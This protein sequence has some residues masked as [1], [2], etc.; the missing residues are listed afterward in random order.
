MTKT[1]LEN[2]LRLW[3]VLHNI[4]P[5]CIH[6]Q[7]WWD[8]SSSWC[9]KN[10]DYPYHNP[11]IKRVAVNNKNDFILIGSNET[12]LEYSQFSHYICE[13]FKANL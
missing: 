2:K 13:K 11:K 4:I 10:S 6:C 1:K 8:K 7:Y 3:K 9:M 5:Q 12:S